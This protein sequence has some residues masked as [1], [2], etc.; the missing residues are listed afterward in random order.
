[1]SQENVALARRYVGGL[2]RRDIEAMLAVCDPEVE[3]RS[4]FSDVLGG[5]FHGHNGIRDYFREFT[6]TFEQSEIEI[7]QVQDSG[8]LVTG[9]LRAHAQARASHIGVEWQ[10]QFAAR[11]RDG[12]LWRIAACRSEAEALEAIRLRE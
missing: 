7:T 12:S 2:D 11:I 6:D 4:F 9:R 8:D 3:F 10:V 1:M 5:A